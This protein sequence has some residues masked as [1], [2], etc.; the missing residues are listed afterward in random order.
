MTERRAGGIAR[1]R[2]RGDRSDP[3][4]RFDQT[5]VGPHQAQAFRLQPLGEANPGCEKLFRGLYLRKK[6][7]MNGVLSIAPRLPIFHL[8]TGNSH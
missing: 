3:F 8:W 7:M 6:S 2:R 1:H 5:S 4:R